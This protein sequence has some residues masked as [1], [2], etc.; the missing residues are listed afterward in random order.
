MYFENFHTPLRVRITQI[1]LLVTCSHRIPSDFTIHLRAQLIDISL[2]QSQRNK[3]FLSVGSRAAERIQRPRGQ[4]KETPS[5]GSEAKG[6]FSG[7][8]NFLGNS[9]GGLRYE[10]PQTLKHWLL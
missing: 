5:P 4:K 3:I 10:V 7:S 2:F 8:R 6:K 1:P 9:T